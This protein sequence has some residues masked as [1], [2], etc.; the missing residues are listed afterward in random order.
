MA[1]PILSRRYFKLTD[2]T[3]FWTSFIHL[4]SSTKLTIFFWIY[5]PMHRTDVFIVNGADLEYTKKHLQNF[6]MNDAF[7]YRSIYIIKNRN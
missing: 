2:L 1:C 7:E 3:D 4:L 5:R 6:M